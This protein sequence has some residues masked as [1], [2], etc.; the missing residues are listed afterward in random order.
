MEPRLQVRHGIIFCEEFREAHQAPPLPLISEHDL[1]HLAF[2]QRSDEEITV[3]RV[4]FLALIQA[5]PDNPL[6]KQ[7]QTEFFFDLAHRTFGGCFIC[8]S[9]STRQI[10]QAGEGDVGLLV[11]EISD[12]LIVA[13]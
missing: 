9:P 12:Q 4:S 10:P 2:Q 6:D 11:A 5:A 8:L 13:A 1:I 3:W 7:S